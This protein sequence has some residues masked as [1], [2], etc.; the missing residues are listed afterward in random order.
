MN[1]R[2]TNRILVLRSRNEAGF[3]MA[4]IAIALG[5]IAFALIA[6]IGILPTGLQTQ[7]ANRE[8]TIINQDARLI[9]QALK[10]GAR[11]TS[12]LSNFVVQLDGGPFLGTTPKFIRQFF[13]PYQS[14]TAIFSAMSGALASRGSD[15]N[16][17]YELVSYV[18]PQVGSANEFFGTILS[19][20][21][22]EVRLRF[23]WPVKPD[24]TVGPEAN[25][26]TVR[27]LI[28]GWYTNGFF[29]P[30]EFLNNK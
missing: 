20:Q 2:R 16:F 6:I 14:H 25:R 22:Y 12:D 30:Q 3:T 28:A 15:L 5:V 1:T 18:T 17:K 24:L 4:E 27:T 13:D 23:A 11:D 19:N 9:L 26:Y 10:D 7:R 21:V 29:Y 8:D